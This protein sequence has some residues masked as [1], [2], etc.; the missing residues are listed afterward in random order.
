MGDVG[1]GLG[2]RDHES[3]VPQVQVPVGWTETTAK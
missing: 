1:G 2:E 3:Q